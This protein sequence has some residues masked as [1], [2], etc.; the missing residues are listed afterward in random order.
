MDLNILWFVLIAVLFTGYF[1]LEG[2][3]FGVGMLLPFLGKNDTERRVILNTIGPHWDGNEVWLITAGGAMFAAFPGWY[4]TLFSGFYLALFIMLLALIVRGIGIEFRS[5]HESLRWRKF[6]DWC[7]CIG[8]FV[9]SL[10]WGV[11]FAN[12]LRGVPIDAKQYFVGNFWDLIN[13]YAI[14]AGLAVLGLFLVQ[15]AAFLSLRTEDPIKYRGQYLAFRLW[16][17]AVVLLIVA[18]FT[19]ML[20]GGN[21]TRQTASSI[22]GLIAAI[23]A[24]LAMLLAGWYLRIKKTGLAFIMNTLTIVLTSATLFLSLFPNVLV[25]ILHPDFS[26]TIYNSASG[27]NTLR[28]MS[29]VALIFMPIVLL[30]QAWS[31]RIFRKRIAMRVEDLHY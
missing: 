15:G 17:P 10:L 7:I 4:A 27:A 23:L 13:L 2:F 29:I 25:S 24:F 30:Y 5:L 28:V 3:D 9:P 26:L 18:L 16:L 11:A 20:Y 1:V 6:W 19:T 31:Y 22:L 12:F 14:I 8:S 21:L